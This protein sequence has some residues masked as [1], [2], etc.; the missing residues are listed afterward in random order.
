M[1]K[2]VLNVFRYVFLSIVSFISVFPFFWMIVAAT[3]KSVEVTKGTVIPGTYFFENLKTLLASDLQYV[4]AFKN[5]IIIA[6][7]TTALAMVVSATVAL[8]NVFLSQ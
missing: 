4:N 5:S 1:R 7:V 2:K 8:T 6:I 3:N